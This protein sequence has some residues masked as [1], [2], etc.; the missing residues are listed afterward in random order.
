MCQWG[1]DRRSGQLSQPTFQTTHVCHDA[2][3]HAEYVVHAQYNL[4]VSA[5]TLSLR[6]LLTVLLIVHL[7]FLEE[8]ASRHS[9]STFS[10]GF[11]HSPKK[12]R[13]V[14]CVAL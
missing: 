7:S 2:L 8:I 5:F 14:A 9:D 4:F 12:S 13:D 6:V 1:T 3:L 10:L 11:W